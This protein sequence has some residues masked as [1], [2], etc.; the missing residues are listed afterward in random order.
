MSATT[1]T[2][3]LPDIIYPTD[4]NELKERMLQGEQSLGVNYYEHGVQ[5]ANQFDALMDLMGDNRAKLTI[6]HTEPRKRWSLPPWLVKH[7]RWIY[8]QLTANRDL[9]RT[10][11]IWHDCGKPLVKVLDDDQAAHYPDHAAVSAKAWLSVGG[12][13]DIAWFIEND[14]VPHHLRSVE[15]TK[16]LAYG[17]DAHKFLV[18]MVTAVCAM[19]ICSPSVK[20]GEACPLDLTQTPGFKIKMKR[21]AY[22]GKIMMRIL[23][24]DQTN[25]VLTTTASQS[26]VE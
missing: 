21:I 5:L 12:D 11:H 1:S 2:S 14:M 4:Q 26:P 13:A 23:Q 18:L 10:Y 8:D 19:H 17:Q 6:N 15:E 16:Q 7:Q 3:T 22:Y 9:Y 25:K 20:E 24:P